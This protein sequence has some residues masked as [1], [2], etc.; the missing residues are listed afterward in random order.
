[1]LA[2]AGVTSDVVTS[3]GPDLTSEIVSHLG[4]S[5]VAEVV[6]SMGPQLVGDLVRE[7]GA[8]YTGGLVLLLS[9]S[10]PLSHVVLRVLRKDGALSGGCF[11]CLLVACLTSNTVWVACMMHAWHHP[12]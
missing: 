12:A 1:V 11:D 2:A 3:F 6:A 4:P 7:W 5:T 8:G 9:S 10:M